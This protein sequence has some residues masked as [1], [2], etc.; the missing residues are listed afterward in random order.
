MKNR[1]IISF[2]YDRKTAR[3]AG[4]TDTIIIIIIIIINTFWDSWCFPWHLL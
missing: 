4:T 1:Y 3:C 2:L